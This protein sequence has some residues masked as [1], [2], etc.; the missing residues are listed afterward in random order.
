M[1]SRL[2]HLLPFWLAAACASSVFLPIVEADR[3]TSEYVTY[4]GTWNT[5][6][7]ISA[8]VRIYPRDAG[9]LVCG[10]WATSRQSTTS[11]M[12]N[13][14]V[15]RAGSAFIGKKRLVHGLGFMRR[16][17]WADN[18]SGAQA[19]CVMSR[20]AWQTEFAELEPALRFPRLVYTEI[21]DSDDGY[22]FRH[23]TVFRQT[24]RLDIAR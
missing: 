21:E 2:P 11:S 15:M 19:D 14:D 22:V 23:D 10:A 9:T 3:V 12:Y 16:A 5:G 24:P 8:V 20:V 4:G 7:G 13:E 17:K 6:G 18:I 1:P